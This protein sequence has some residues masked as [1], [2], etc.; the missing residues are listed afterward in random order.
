MSAMPVVPVMFMMAVQFTLS[1][2]LSMTLTC[3]VHD[4]LDDY[5]ICDVRNVQRTRALC[6]V[7]DYPDDCNY[8]RD[9]YGDETDFFDVFDALGDYVVGVRMVCDAVIVIYVMSLM[10]TTSVFPLFLLFK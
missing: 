4:V 6:H 1:T 8:L 9:V 7:S 10:S 2:M 3:D 5:D